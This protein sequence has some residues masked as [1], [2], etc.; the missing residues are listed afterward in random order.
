MAIQLTNLKLEKST[1]LSWMERLFE[2]LIKVYFSEVKL[3]LSRRL[4][5]LQLSTSS[6]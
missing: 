5:Q 3:T 6:I 4:Y 1:T 2:K